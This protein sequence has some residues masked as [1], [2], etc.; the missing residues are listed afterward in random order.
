MPRKTKHHPLLA[1]L[2][3]EM[4]AAGDPA[5]AAGQQAY[6]KSAM[7][8]HGL[9]NTETR[10]LCR[11][12]F[13]DYEIDPSDGT[14][15]RED[16]LAIWRGADHREERY[17]A[18]ELLQL[19]RARVLHTMAAISMLE[20]LIVTGAWWDY[21]DTIASHDL[22]SV[23]RNEP[24]AMRRA[25]LTWSKSE[26]MWKRRSSILCQLSFKGETDLDLLYACIEPSIASK[27]F[28]LRKAIGWALRQYAWTDPLEVDRYVRANET[29]LSGLSIREALKNMGPSRS[30]GRADDELTSSRARG[31]KRRSA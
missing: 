29:R 4:T 10:A 26:D 13:A 30:A 15:W 3:R 21:V 14:R 5:R 24:K 16:V 6:M 9:R 8:Y 20:E 23:L 7:P 12:V 31:A 28:F 27:E 22:G 25:M 19:R 11:K 17:A 18:I 1:A 2:R